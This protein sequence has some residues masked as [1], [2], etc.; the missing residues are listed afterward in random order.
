MDIAG[1][2]RTVF[3]A[4][5][6]EAMMTY[7]KRSTGH[8]SQH[9]I[10]MLPGTAESRQEIFHFGFVFAKT[11]DLLESGKATVDPQIAEMFTQNN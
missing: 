3:D 6:I 4:A 8:E 1:I 2:D 7:M 10:V 11:L 5:R 9:K